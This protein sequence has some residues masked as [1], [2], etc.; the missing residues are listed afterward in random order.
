MRRSPRFLTSSAILW[1]THPPMAA[2]A[3]PTGPPTRAPIAPQ[4]APPVAA[5]T[6]SAILSGLPFLAISGARKAPAGQDPVLVEQQ[7]PAKPSESS[8]PFHLV[9]DVEDPKG[10]A[11]GCRIAL[12]RHLESQ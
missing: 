6:T 5:P 4:A 8:P 2:P 9:D 11:A 12:L 1:P 10:G 7:P 3:T